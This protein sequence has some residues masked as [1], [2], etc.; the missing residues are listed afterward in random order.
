MPICLVPARS[1]SKRIPNKNIRKVRGKPMM[2]WPLVAAVE[3]RL[4]SEVVVSTDSRE[5]MDIAH[6][7]PGVK[8]FIR[9]P[10][11]ASDT[12]PL[13]AVLYDAMK[14]ARCSTWCMLLPTALSVTPEILIASYNAFRG[15]G[16]PLV[17][18]TRDRQTAERAM[19]VDRFGQLV[20]L[21]KRGIVSRTQDCRGSYHD[22]GA[23]Y[24]LWREDFML[25]WRLLHQDILLQKPMPF[26]ID[27]VDIDDEADLI[28]ATRA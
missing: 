25:R 22:A 17:S 26:V 8:A 5:Y 10:D 1:G 4:F 15:E 7:V 27:A 2:H 12:A 14:R 18:V 11:A 13:E 16:G 20:P 23:L 9:D 28:E 6:K 3:S 21:W 19:R 24:W